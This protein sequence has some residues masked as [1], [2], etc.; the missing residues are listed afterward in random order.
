MNLSAE[1]ITALLQEMMARLDHPL[2][3]M[4]PVEL[5]LKDPL[6]RETNTKAVGW[7]R[8]VTGDITVELY[9]WL[10]TLPDNAILKG[11][12]W[13]EEAEPI[14]APEIAKKEKKA[15]K[16]KGPHGKFWQEMV[17]AGINTL[18]E[19]QA[20]FDIQNPDKWNEEVRAKFGKTSLT[21]VSP[22]E[23]I[24]YVRK[25]SK[26]EDGFEIDPSSLMDKINAVTKKVSPSPTLPPGQHFSPADILGVEPKKLT[27]VSA[28]SPESPEEEVTE[29]DETFIK[30]H[31]LF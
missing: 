9:E 31:N 6:G 11:F 3:E 20:I 12:I 15:V 4:R 25:N 21:F 5:E 23:V 22:E 1:Q 14:Q 29:S 7:T 17:H 18:P 27:F 10:K 16:E 28:T 19:F 8:K 30:G 2:S 26:V 24:Q 13:L